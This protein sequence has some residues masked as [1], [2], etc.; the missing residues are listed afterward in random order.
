VNIF[1][2]IVI[3]LVAGGLARWIVKDNRSGCL[4]TTAVG[5]LGAV[6]GGWLMNASGRKGVNEFD[7]RSILV[8]VLGAVLL[9]LI[10]QAVSGRQAGRRG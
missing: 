2:W 10:L 4:Y 5:V 6:I 7:I 8:S 9:L 3:G 1:A